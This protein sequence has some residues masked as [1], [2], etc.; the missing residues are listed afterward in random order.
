MDKRKAS[1]ILSLA[2]LIPA[3]LYVA[4]IVAQFM[5]NIHAW[6]AAGSDYG[7]SPGLPSL[8]VGAVAQ[9]L[10]TFPEGIISLGAV[11]IGLALFIIFGLHIDLGNRGVTDADRNLTISSSGSY[12]T[13]G[14]MTPKEAEKAFEVTSPKSTDQDILGAIDKNRVITLGK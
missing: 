11:L 2:V 4:G 1:T 8:T 12:G 3:L 6:E 14:F 13:A 5:I 7:T 10:T 9:A